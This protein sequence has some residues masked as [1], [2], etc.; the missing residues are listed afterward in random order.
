MYLHVLEFAV[1]S[2]RNLFQV[3]AFPKGILLDLGDA[4]R[5]SYLFD[6]AHHETAFYYLFQSFTEHDA[7]KIFTP[8]ERIEM[9]NL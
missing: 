7:L 8:A 1:S 4:V 2:E 6:P 3:F 5:H 9:Y